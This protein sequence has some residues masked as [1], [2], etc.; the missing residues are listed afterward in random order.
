M[1][2]NFDGNL[3]YRDY[4]VHI[5]TGI[6]FNLF[7]LGAFWYSLPPYWYEYEFPHELILSLLAIPVLF[8]EG[9]FILA[10]NRLFLVVIPQEIFMYRVWYRQYLRKKQVLC[11]NKAIEDV[12]Y[13]KVANRVRIR[14]YKKLYQ[15]SFISKILFFLF[16]SNRILG[17]KIVREDK[18]G[19]LIETSDTKKEAA[20]NRYY[21]LSDFFKGVGTAAFIALVF[22]VCQHNWKVVCI[23]LG[24]IILA[25]Q[26]ARFFSML[27]VKYKY[28]TTKIVEEVSEKENK[29]L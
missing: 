17:Q 24:I 3:S 22:A 1:S 12:H 8:L 13:K 15:K 5:F 11:K 16:F 19:S 27:Y 28:V 21:V 2:T 10:I 6:L 4:I 25:K 26:R 14:W 29:E 23:L 20:S 7:M 18:E 9:H